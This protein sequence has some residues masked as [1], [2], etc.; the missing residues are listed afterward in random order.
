MSARSV[1]C[2]AR[3]RL[4]RTPQ[5]RTQS[6]VWNDPRCR[7]DRL[8]V[9]CCAWQ[10][11]YGPHSGMPCNSSTHSWWVFSAECTTEVFLDSF[12]SFGRRSQDGLRVG[13]DVLSI[14]I[15]AATR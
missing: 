1:L 7:I 8:V 3:M 13:V 5:A 10:R 15:R 9:D 11:W 14:S 6:L 12:Y 4:H 2:L